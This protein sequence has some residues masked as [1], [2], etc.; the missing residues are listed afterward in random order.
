[1]AYG[2]TD[3]IFEETLLPLILGVDIDIDWVEIYVGNI[4]SGPRVTYHSEKHEKI[5]VSN[6]QTSDFHLGLGRFFCP[7]SS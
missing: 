3:E 2:V 4:F 6:N 1:M 7:L 5:R